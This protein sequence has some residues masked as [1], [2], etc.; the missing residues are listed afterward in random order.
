MFHFTV[1]YGLIVIVPLLLVVKT[2]EIELKKKC[3]V[4]AK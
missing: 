2:M 3:L 1:E 4:Y